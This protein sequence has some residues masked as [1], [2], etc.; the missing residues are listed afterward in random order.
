MRYLFAAL[1]AA[2][3]SFATLTPVLAQSVKTGELRCDVSSG[4][5]AI[6]GSQQAV[7]CT[8]A[9]SQP[10]P[11]QSYAGTITRFGLDIGTIKG[12]VMSWLV[13]SPSLAGPAE[14]Q[15][16][17]VGVSASVS[18]GRG[19]GANVLVGGDRNT[20]SLQ[21]VSVEVNQGF[22]IAAGVSELL[23]RRAP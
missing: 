3:L 6:I 2:A 5:G 14:L 18:A 4:L 23:L 12:G 11:A 9:P 13:Y 22:N 21:P 20:V 16:A 17:Y 7:N 8:F 10:G 19:L 15:G 1:G